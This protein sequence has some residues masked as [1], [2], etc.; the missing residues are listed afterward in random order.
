MSKL[1]YMQFRLVLLNED[2]SVKK[3]IHTSEK[4]K[5]IGELNEA[6]YGYLL[7]ANSKFNFSDWE[8]VPP[9]EFQVKEFGTDEWNYLSDPVSNWMNL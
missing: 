6:I 5:T 7:E 9:M 2:D 8:N 4:Y 1:D 3:V